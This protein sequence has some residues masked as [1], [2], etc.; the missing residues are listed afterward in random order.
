MCSLVCVLG[1]KHGSH[2]RAA[3]ALNSASSNLKWRF[4][5]LLER[6]EMLIPWPLPASTVQ[7][8]HISPFSLSLSSTQS[9]GPL[10][11]LPTATLIFLG[12]STGLCSVFCL[13][14]TCA[15][16]SAVHEV[17]DFLRETMACPF[18]SNVNYPF[19]GTSF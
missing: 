8:C 17:N 1:T 18:L 3:S 9:H 12:A 16:E 19:S 2:T 5:F 11:A 13:V 14:D 6:N 7:S 15:P 4:Q 10:S